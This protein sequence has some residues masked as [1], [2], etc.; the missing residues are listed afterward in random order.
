M[1]RGVPRARGEASRVTDVPILHRRV[2][3]A[4]VEAVGDDPFR[5]MHGVTDREFADRLQPRIPDKRLWEIL[6]NLRDR[7]VIEIRVAAKAPARRYVPLDDAYK[8]AAE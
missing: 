3:R 2:C 8:A 7:G 6:R 1:R 5:R 4:V